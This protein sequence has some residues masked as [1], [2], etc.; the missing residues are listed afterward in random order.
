[1]DSKNDFTKSD[2][3]LS[4]D[5][6]RVLNLVTSI[7]YS[8]FRKEDSSTPSPSPS[9]SSSFEKETA[10]ILTTQDRPVTTQLSVSEM[11]FN[12]LVL[13]LQK[14]D[15]SEARRHVDVMLALVPPTVEGG[16]NF[17]QMLF[18]AE[19]IGILE[20]DGLKFKKYKSKDVIL[21][22]G[23]A[24]TD[25]LFLMLKGRV[26]VSSKISSSIGLPLPPCVIN[27]FVKKVAGAD[28]IDQGELIAGD[29]VNLMSFLTEK[30]V[31]ATIKA[32][33]DVELIALTSKLF[34][35][36]YS[37]DSEF[38]RYLYSVTLSSAKDL[39]HKLKNPPNI[40][41]CTF[42]AVTK[43]ISGTSKLITGDAKRVY[44]EN[45]PMFYIDKTD[46]LLKDGKKAEAS[47]SMLK[48]ALLYEN[49]KPGLSVSLSK[50]A[51]SLDPDNIEAKTLISRVVS[52]DDLAA[53]AAHKVEFLQLLQS[54]EILALLKNTTL[55]AFPDGALIVKKGDFGD[56]MFLIEEGEVEFTSEVTIEDLS[57]KI[58][59]GTLR[60]GDVFGEIAILESG[61]RSANGI[62]RG[63]NVF[64]RE[65]HKE[66]IFSLIEQNPR[67][68]YYLT[69]LSE[70]RKNRYIEFL[71]QFIDVLAE[72]EIVALGE[73]ST[74]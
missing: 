10:T 40:A 50:T 18:S 8:P 26:E 62:A 44:A 58:S 31:E 7:F 69:E 1:M 66:F 53:F 28:N 72:R 11:A 73:G 21:N 65:I 67:L 60:K 64:V 41:L 43:A 14:K 36:L 51:L 70:V 47:I 34:Y 56:T 13:A 2:S 33:E 49:T 61:E 9:F 35:K 55:R 12:N 4:A 52:E 6:K 46:Q 37:P 57:D 15:Y 54:G 39:E 71:S 20:K 32:K 25:Y 59:Y 24:Y 30:Q 23:D 27:H 19:N 3:F 29:L 38:V 48:A 22:E 16:V 74:K 45:D 68:S 42:S 5:M 63:S 17:L